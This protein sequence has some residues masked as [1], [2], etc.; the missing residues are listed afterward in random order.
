MLLEQWD[1]AIANLSVRGAAPSY[2]AP[3]EEEELLPPSPL[4]ELSLSAPSTGLPST[5]IPTIMVLEGEIGKDEVPDLGAMLFRIAARGVTKVVID[6]AGVTHF[7]FR[8]VKPLLQR[9]ELFREAGGDLKLSGLSPYLHAIFR[10]A[11]GAGAFDFFAD[12]RAA[13]AAFD[14]SG[15]NGSGRRQPAT[16]PR[17]TRG[18]DE[19]V[20]P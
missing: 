14:P 20:S 1:E 12:R 3:L 15:D 19:F 6:F 7:D 9:A 5:A 4:D 18:E 2:V 13:E 11:G 8:G 10:S 16:P 17:G